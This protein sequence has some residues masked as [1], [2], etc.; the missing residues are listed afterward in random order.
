M[1][2]L[3]NL[4]LLICRHGATAGCS[5]VEKRTNRTRRS[6]AT[7]LQVLDID[8]D[9]DVDDDDDDDDDDGDY[10]YD[11][12]YDDFLAV[13]LCQWCLL[14]VTISV[15]TFSLY[16]CRLVAQAGSDTL[17]AIAKRFQGEHG[18]YS[19]K[20]IM[21]RIREVACY[22]KQA[23]DSKKVCVCVRVFLRAYVCACV[24]VHCV[25]VYK[26]MHVCMFVFVCRW[27]CGSG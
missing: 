24:C 14:V 22:E 4:S 18:E 8:D 13:V 25:C 9:D 3:T 23:G 2:K 19:Q 5:Q 12:G 21:A 26:C 15:A 17:D 20:Q 7:S 27:G 10:G 6:F 1:V 11:Y 16:K